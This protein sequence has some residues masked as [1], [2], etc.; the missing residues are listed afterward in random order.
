MTGT[1][2]RINVLLF[3]LS[4]GTHWP[5]VLSSIALSPV[6]KSGLNTQNTT[7]KSKVVNR[8]SLITSQNVMTE[9][10]QC[11]IIQAEAHTNGIFRLYIQK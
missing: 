8:K 6:P 3:K 9:C 11:V 1:E 7:Q 5:L 10:D 2:K 4:E